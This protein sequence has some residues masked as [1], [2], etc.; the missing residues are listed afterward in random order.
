MMLEPATRWNPRIPDRL[1]FGASRGRVIDASEA[2]WGIVTHG[3]FLS[4]AEVRWVTRGSTDAR[5]V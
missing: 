3:L 1:R 2:G 5:A 4:N